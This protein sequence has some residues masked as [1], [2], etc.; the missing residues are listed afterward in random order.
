MTSPLLGR[1]FGPLP[2][3]DIA[4]LLVMERRLTVAIR[5]HLG[6][7]ALRLGPDE[8]R[9]RPVQPL[10]ASR[11][12]PE[13]VAPRGAR[14]ARVRRRPAA[15]LQGDTTADVVILGGGYTGLW[16]AYQLKRLDP[17]VDVVVLE[18]DICGGGPSGRNGGFVNSYWNDLPHLTRMLGDEAALRL[19]RAGESSVAAI[20]AFCD[21]HDVDAWYRA[22]GDLS[23]AASRRCRIGAWGDLVID[24]GAAR[25]RRATSRCSR[26]MPCATSSTRRCSGAASRDATARPCS[27]RGSFAGCGESSWSMGVR[28]H[29]RTARHAVRRGRSGRGR[30]ALG[31]PCG[32]A[33]RWSR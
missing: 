24:R 23:V 28:V 15:P 19:C 25:A 7:P 12:G 17:G 22:D 6:A 16:T 32:P 13:L 27:R 21:E 1:F 9:D 31:E 11:P 4:R 33:R 5:V 14:A 18:Q 20:G 10:G 30:D 8:H 29:E 3:P 26:P 2:S